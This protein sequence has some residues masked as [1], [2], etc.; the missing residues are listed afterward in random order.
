MVVAIVQIACCEIT[1]VHCQTDISQHMGGWLHITL[2]PNAVKRLNYYKTGGESRTRN[3]KSS[4]L[5]R[6][7]MLYSM[8]D[9]QASTFSTGS[10]VYT[11]HYIVLMDNRL[12]LGDKDLKSVVSFSLHYSRFLEYQTAVTARQALWERTGWWH[13]GGWPLRWACT[14]M[15]S[16]ADQTCNMGRLR[17]LQDFVLRQTTFH[18]VL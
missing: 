6:L 16:L 18:A 4:H 2:I 8:S 1:E 12:Y 11:I 13:S 10:H 3:T 14:S 7:D 17:L 9:P 15:Y 5:D